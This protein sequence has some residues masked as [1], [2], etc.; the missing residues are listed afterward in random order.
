MFSDSP[1]LVVVKEIQEYMIPLCEDEIFH[2]E[3]SLMEEGCRDP[4]VVWAKND[5]E[6]I[7]VDGHNRYE[8]C[9]RRNIP[10]DLKI[11]SFAS[12]EQ[13]KSWMI[14]NQMGRRNLTP[15]QLRYYR[16][17]KYLSAKKKKGGFENIKSKGK[18]ENST[19][20]LLSK[21]FSVSASTIK[22]DA[23]FAEAL[24]LLGSF[25]AALKRKILSGQ[26]KV[27]NTNLLQLINMKNPERIVKA[28]GRRV[29]NKGKPEP[30]VD[31]AEVLKPEAKIKRM[32]DIIIGT[33]N[34][35]IK[36]KRL[37]D[38]KELKTLVDRLEITLLT[39]HFVT[40]KQTSIQR[41]LQHT[42]L[43]EK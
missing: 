41:R 17:L 22:R 29:L 6:F 23:K 4:L 26:T 20:R 2:L 31:N 38:I 37:E 14:E 32:R 13:V 15:Y 18:T 34:R 9:K 35:A 43:Q 1:S 16:G 42:N 12:L 3:K 8:I 33:M 24:N 27:K 21:E 28:L 11:V 25:D 39:E 10:F 7:I 19:A 5:T 40:H 30:K 36:D